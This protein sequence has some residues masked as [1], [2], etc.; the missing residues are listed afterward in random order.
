MLRAVRPVDLIHILAER[1]QHFGH[2]PGL[3]E[4]SAGTV[5]GVAFE[6]FRDLA[7]T[8]LAEMR[9]QTAQNLSSALSCFFGAAVDLHM[10]ADKRTQQPRPD[11]PLMVGGIAALLVALV[12]A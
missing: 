9:F 1:A 11:R 12:A 7:Q 3:G 4:A 5:R 8:G 6:D 10:R 2:A